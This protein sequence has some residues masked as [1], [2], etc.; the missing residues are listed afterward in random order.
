[1]Q[2]AGGTPGDCGSWHTPTKLFGIERAD[3][4]NQIVA[5]LRPVQAR[6]RIADVVGHRRGARREDRDV[7]AALALK[8][9]L[10]VLQALTNLVVAD[11]DGAL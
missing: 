1:M 5:V 2:L 3:A 10:R 6:G 9:Q 11:V 4:M 7:G 8:L